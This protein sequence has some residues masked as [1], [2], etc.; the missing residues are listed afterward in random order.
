MKKEFNM[1]KN[2]K[3]L[4]QIMLEGI[5][6]SD[7]RIFELNNVKNAEFYFMGR[8]TRKETEEKIK[9]IFWNVN[10]YLYCLKKDKKVLII[11]ELQKDK[12][13]NKMGEKVNTFKIS[14]TH[15]QELE[16]LIFPELPI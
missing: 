15:I 4:N 12:F 11:G 10:E 9:V 1:V 6:S 3:L 13:I 5:I 8:F 16:N 2:K 7:I 14:A